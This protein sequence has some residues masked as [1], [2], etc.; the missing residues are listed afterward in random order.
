MKESNVLVVDDTEKNLQLIG[1]LLQNKGIAITFATNGKQAIIAAQKKKPDLILL[2][3]MMP[4]MDGYEVCEYLKKDPETKGIP[5]IFLTSKNE[6]EDIVKGF[7]LGAVDYLTKPF[8][9]EEL[10]S[11]V[12]THLDLKKSHDIIQE[13]NKQLEIKNLTILSHA[14]QVE[15]LNENLKHKNIELKELINT[16]DKFFSIISHDLKGPLFNILTFT[17]LII[18]TIENIKKE[19][20]FKIVSSL[21]DSTESSLKLL[22]NLLDWSRSQTGILNISP[23]R[24]ELLYVINDVLLTQKKI[25]SRKD[26]EITV[27][28]CGDKIIFADEAMMNTILRNLISNAI[29]FTPKGGKINI[30]ASYKKDNENN[31]VVVEIKDNGTGMSP[32]TL[33]KLFVLNKSD[34]IRGT[35]GEKGTGL[36]LVL[37]KEFIEKNSGK[38]N[39]KSEIGKGSSFI[40]SVPAI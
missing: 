25:A 1:N 14:K 34:S 21:K 17:D 31:Q 20:L 2:D 28:D 38:L 30:I 16:K 22:E 4:E 32:E 27:S 11:R 33:S 37:C 29:K 8:K 19:K 26:I 36:G 13:Q 7:A 24:I 18:S 12:L 35:D 5:I 9:K 3:I 6:T 10:V 23:V 39:V 15:K 40:F